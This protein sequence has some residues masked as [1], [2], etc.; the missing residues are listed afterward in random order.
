MEQMYFW[1]SETN[2]FVPY[3]VEYELVQVQDIDENGQAV[4]SSKLVKK[5]PPETLYTEEQVRSIL[6]NR[7]ANQ[8]IKDVNG[9]PTAVDIDW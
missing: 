7:T 2:S 3:T 4:E 5:Q 8:V 1:Q 9:T 6:N